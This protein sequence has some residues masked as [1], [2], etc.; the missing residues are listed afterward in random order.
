MFKIMNKIL[1]I[2][3]LLMVSHCANAQTN[4]NDIKG[5]WLGSMQIPEGPKLRIGIE[6]FKKADGQWGGNI[7][8]L[9]QG[10][11]Y[12]LVSDVSV[13][14]DTFTLHLAGAPINIV[15]QID[16]SH[17]KIAANFNQGEHVFPLDLNKVDALPETVRKQTPTDISG[18][19][20]QEVRYKNTDDN[21]W[22]SA[23]LT[24]P[25]GNKRH[26]AVMLIAGSG[27]NHRD[28]YHA[29]HRTFKVLADHLTNNGHVVLRADKRG[30]YKSSGEYKDGDVENYARD[31]QA[32]IQYLKSLEQVDPNRIILIGHSEGSLV[33]IM[34]AQLETVNGIVSLAGP[35]MSI[36]DVLLDQ[37]QTEPAAKGATTAETD[38][39]LKFSQRFYSIILNTPKIAQRK[40]KIQALYDNLQGKEAE[41]INKWVNKRHGTLSIAGA[42]SES[43]SQWL[44]LDPL[45]Y[46]QKFQ[47]NALILN[48]DKDS[49]VPANANVSGIVNAM[50]AQEGNVQSHIFEGVN[51][52][53]QPAITG[54]VN[55]YAE[56]EETI[57]SEVLTTISKWLE[58]TFS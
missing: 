45:I 20:E 55:E 28:S 57:D 42:E 34:A 53:F 33:A 29:G 23:T 40:I 52:L 27:P 21:T 26:P 2:S 19:R 47:G 11:R 36:L 50:K 13:N 3:I 58:N 22:L 6:V 54:A 44:K 37:D 35:G 15:G 18:Y 12:M 48:G 24:L 30:V 5:A 14:N 17:N 49:Q 56:I 41:I 7:A 43:F 4:L 1:V 39:L 8:S 51:H 25:K 32:A 10:S 38:V 31:T 9:D 46:W 16:K